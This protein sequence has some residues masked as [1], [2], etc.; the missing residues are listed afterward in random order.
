MS[1][2]AH[3]TLTARARNVLLR[4]LFCGFV[5]IV[6]IRGTSRA[7]PRVDHFEGF[8]K[9]LRLVAVSVGYD[10]RRCVGGTCCIFHKISEAPQ[11]VVEGLFS[12]RELFLWHRSCGSM[13]VIGIVRLPLQMDGSSCPHPPDRHTLP[14]GGLEVGGVHGDII[15]AVTTSFLFILTASLMLLSSC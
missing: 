1:A 5:A 13:S 4:S 7:A 9:V 11:V 3:H 15:E 12:F 6:A 8:S 14:A 10:T 2:L